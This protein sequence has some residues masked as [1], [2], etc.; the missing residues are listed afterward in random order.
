MK[1]LRFRTRR[2][3]LNHYQHLVD[4]GFAD[5]KPKLKPNTTMIDSLQNEIYSILRLWNGFELFSRNN[6]ASWI[7]ANVEWRALSELEGILSIMHTATKIMH[8]EQ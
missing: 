5:I 4:G 1:F 2:A 6:M 3:K 8:T 7:L